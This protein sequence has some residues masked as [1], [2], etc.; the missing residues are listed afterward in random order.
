MIK[1]RVFEGVII[2][3]IDSN[4][5]NYESFKKSI[6]YLKSKKEIT[7][8]KYSGG[9]DT[10]HFSFEYLNIICKLTYSGFFGTELRV[11]KELLTESDLPKVRQWALEIY[12]FIHNNESPI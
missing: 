7:N 8:S 9:F 4:G 3:D 10:E 11:D 2:F 12:N 5:D 6:E 1:E